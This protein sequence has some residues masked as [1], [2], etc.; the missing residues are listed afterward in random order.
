MTTLLSV[1][2]VNFMALLAQAGE[3]E[4]YLRQLGVD[5]TP[6]LGE[7]EVQRIGEAA[8]EA[9]RPD[10]DELVPLVEAKSALAKAR[11]R[12]TL[13]AD[14]EPRRSMVAFL[15][16]TQITCFVMGR[17]EIF[18]SQVAPDAL[19][20]AIR[21]AI[22]DAESAGAHWTVARWQGPDRLVSLGHAEAGVDIVGKPEWASRSHATQSL[23][24]LVN[25]VL[26]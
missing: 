13:V 14:L 23:A 9:S 6:T 5:L 17:E 24:E 4:A 11:G 25:S 2:H 19:A 1:D 12:V 10:A 7:A 16:D 18:V 3:G 21:T 8:R 22:A 15:A 20:E 26:V